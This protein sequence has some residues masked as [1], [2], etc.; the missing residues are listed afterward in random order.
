MRIDS[1]F[2]VAAP[3]QEVWTYM[4]DVQRVA[5]CMPGAELTQVVNDR[6]FKGRV[7]V[8]MGPVALAFAGTI[9]I[10]ERNDAAHRVVMKASGSEEKGKGQAEATVTSFMQAE[11]NGTR[12]VVQQ[13]INMSGAVAQYGA[14]M[15]Q[16]ATNVLMKQFVSCMQADLA[17]ARTGAPAGPRKAAKPVSGLTLGF[18][19]FLMSIKRF[20]GGLF[21][22]KSA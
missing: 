6:Q 18:Q 7:K 15:I 8:K 19:A 14:R 5:P 9:N 4:L 20:F 22:K 12:V 17:R 3:V 2:T 13:D 11:G 16:D 1:E 21:K 10:V